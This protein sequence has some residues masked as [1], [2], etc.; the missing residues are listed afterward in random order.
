MRLRYW[1]RR[2]WR[3]CF[4]RRALL[5]VLVLAGFA[6]CSSA[7][8]PPQPYQG[9]HAIHAGG[10]VEPLGEERLL[11]PQVP[12]RI[13]RVLVE[14][15]DTVTAGQLVAEL[16]NAEQRAAL[17][18]ARAQVTLRR[19]ELERLRNGPRREDIAAAR[20]ARDEAAAL[21]SQ[22][23][24]D[25]KRRERM[26]ERKLIAQELLDQAR[27]QAATAT[28]ARQR[29]AAQLAVLLAGSRAEDIA[30]AEAALDAATGQAAQ[31][32]A[33]LEKTRVRSPIAGIVLERGLNPGETV[34]ALTPSPVASIG[35]MHQLMVRADID[36]LDVARVHVGAAAQVSADAF[37]GRQ[38]AGRVVRVARRMGQRLA[39]TD[40]PT[41]RRDAKTLQALIA[42]EPG[43][44]LPVGLRV[45]VTIE[46]TGERA[47]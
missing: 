46:A 9:G 8:P 35:D 44:P 19:A 41:Q 11:I 16:E 15:G 12:G 40:D 14:E 10:L 21:E 18:T 27:T 20:A 3:E 37:P 45:D 22:A 33:L 30:A 43:T 47:P 17:E 2:D 36:E 29:A 31:A 39:A 25:L 13:D 42:L 38:F 1:K 28:A 6:A 4:P 7:P 32:Q 23:A 26:A 24:L 5:A 34:T